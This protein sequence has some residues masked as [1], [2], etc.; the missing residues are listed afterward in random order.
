MN[1]ERIAAFSSGAL[2]GNPAGIVLCDSLPTADTMQSLAAQIGYSETAFAAPVD[3]GWRVR[4]FSPQVEVDFCGHATIA[5]AAVLAKKFASGV[6]NLSLNQ[7][8]ISVEGYYSAQQWGA[9]FQSPATH[10]K[11][12]GIDMLQD[13]LA[14][15]AL[16]HSDLDSRIAPV[17]AFAGGNHLILAL[18]DKQKLSAMNYNQKHGADLS[19]R[20][21]LVTF[22]LVFAQSNRVFHSRNPFP[23][24]GIFEDP[25]TGAA[26]AALGGYLRELNWPHEGAISIYQGEDMGMPSRLQAEISA[27]QGAGIKVSGT[28]RSLD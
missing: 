14:L 15:F 19:L 12:L 22:N 27:V 21:G 20:A 13:V 6:F 10:S 2:G 1:I 25:A 23:V 7:A 9:S 16:D 3:T 26:A 18:K 28:V 24:G 8:Q 17:I 5:L 11:A 4:Y